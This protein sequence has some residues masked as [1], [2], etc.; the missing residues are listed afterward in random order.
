[1]KRKSAFVIAFGAVILATVVVW[2]L[3]SAGRGV[4]SIDQLDDV[5]YSA[6][7]HWADFYQSRAPETTGWVHLPQKHDGMIF[8]SS[9]NPELQ[10]FV[11]PQVCGECHPDKFQGQRETA[12]FRTSSAASLQTVL[13]EFGNENGRLKTR[14]PHLHFEMTAQDEGLYQRVTVQKDGNTYEHAERFDLVVGSGNHGQTYLYWRGDE[15]YQLP[16]GYFSELGGW[17]NSPGFYR[18]GTADFARG[19]GHRCLDCHATFI[20][21]APAGDVRYDRASF[22][23][24]V[25]CVRC[26]GHGWAHVQYHR[27]HPKERTPRY[28]VQPGE[29]PRDR[30]NEVCAQC[31][32]GV[33][34]LLA[35]AFTYQPGEPL[36]DYLRLD[37]DADGAQND[38]P[39]A[40]NQLAR[41]VKSRCY[42]ESESLTCASCHNPHR[43]ER[44]D[45]KLFAQRCAK[46]HPVG[47][48]QLAGQSS[49]AIKEHCVECHMPSRRD[50]DDAMQTSA[51][52]LLPLLRDH[53][54]KVWP[55]VT[56]QVMKKALSK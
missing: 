21:I 48:C 22:I 4:R 12:H 9:A 56:Q 27:T 8:K 51:G 45:L 5:Y 43:E 26:H 40:A 29:L 52:E 31:H 50:V 44:G 2:I 15:L 16:I 3:T 42:Q 54:I 20:A 10:G 6:P 28:I 25:T 17:V 39:H 55:D 1:M 53:Y 32:S 37:A 34:E 23:S 18:D 49:D 41:L 11:R 24:G 46:C 30:A 47:D 13:G 35:P 7:T 19:I 38:D 36:G 33:G 14:D